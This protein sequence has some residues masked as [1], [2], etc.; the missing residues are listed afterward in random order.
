MDGVETGSTEPH[1]GG[2]VKSKRTETITLPR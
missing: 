1:I 2:P